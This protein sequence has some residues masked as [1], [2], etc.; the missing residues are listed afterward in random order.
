MLNLGSKRHIFSLYL[1]ISQSVLFGAQWPGYIN[2]SD[3]SFIQFIY[4]TIQW[5]FHSFLLILSI[6]FIILIACCAENAAVASCYHQTNQSVL[7]LLQHFFS[8]FHCCEFLSIFFFGRSHFLFAL[9]LCNQLKL[10]SHYILLQSLW[11]RIPFMCDNN[12]FFVPLLYV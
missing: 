3:L 8:T 1:F 5:V 10:F 9:S 11:N 7:S 4:S 6:L 12:I 2:T